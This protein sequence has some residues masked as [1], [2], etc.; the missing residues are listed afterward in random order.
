M[1]RKIILDRLNLFFFLVLLSHTS[2]RFVY[3]LRPWY[4][5][6]EHDRA[7]DMVLIMQIS[8]LAKKIVPD[9]KNYCAARKQARNRLSDAL[10]GEWEELM[11][12]LLQVVAHHSGPTTRLHVNL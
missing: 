5:S 7:R 10:A 2:P 9:G 1:R 6:R 11:N 8:I 12:F 3:R 4:V